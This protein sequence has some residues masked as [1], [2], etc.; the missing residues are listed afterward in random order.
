M[1]TALQP[2]AMRGLL[3][4]A[5]PSLASLHVDALR[6]EQVRRSSSLR[7]HPWPLTLCYELEL[8]DAAGTRSTERF[9]AKVHRNGAS[10]AAQA[11]TPALHLP[12]LDMLL[13]PWPHDPG[14][15]QLARLL[16]PALAGANLPAPLHDGTPLPMELLRHEPER[17]ALLRCR[18]THSAGPIYGKTFADDTASALHRRFTHLH[19][20]SQRQPRTALVA[21]PLALDS[22]TRTLW[23]AEAPGRPLVPDVQACAAVGRALAWLHRAALAVPGRRD[24]T[25]WLAELPRRAVKIGRA[26]PELQPRATALVRRLQQAAAALPPGPQTLIHGDFHPGQ[27]W[28]HEGRPVFFDFDEFTLGHPMEDLASFSVKLEQAGEIEAAAA[29]IDAYRRA[30]PGYFE[31]QALLWHRAVQA[32]LQ[33]ARAFVFQVPGWPREVARRLQRAEALAQENLA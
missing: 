27:V 2:E 31:P 11:G 6:I 19:A 16:D 4:G 18:P 17:R 29:F 26:L 15:P 24:T 33:A 14:L 12:Q 10:A 13:W 3:Q 7:R 20:F 28:Q 5:L 8:R 23:L 25:H 9:Y 1:D 22:A 30:A 21:A 32:L